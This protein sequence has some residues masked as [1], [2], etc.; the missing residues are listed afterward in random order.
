LKKVVNN[1]KDTLNGAQQIAIALAPL[2]P[3]GPATI[4]RDHV[5]A[6]YYA[7]LGGLTNIIHP[8]LEDTRCTKEIIQLRNMASHGRTVFDIACEGAQHNPLLDNDNTNNTSNTTFSLSVYAS[9]GIARS[10]ARFLHP[11]SLGQYDIPAFYLAVKTNL[12]DI[13]QLWLPSSTESKSDNT[14]LSTSH[15][16]DKD[17]FLY[18]DKDRHTA[19]HTLCLTSISTDIHN[20]DDYEACLRT[21][22]LLGQYITKEFMLHQPDTYIHNFYTD[23]Y[24]A[25]KL[26]SVTLIQ[27]WLT[28]PYWK[29]HNLITFLTNIQL[30]PEQT[31]YFDVVCEAITN[32]HPPII[33]SRTTNYTTILF[34][35][36]K[37]LGPLN[38]NKVNQTIFTLC[39][40]HG[41][42]DIIQY[43][44]EDLQYSQL[45]RNNSSIIQRS[46]STARTASMYHNPYITDEQKSSINNTNA[47]LTTYLTNEQPLLLA[48]MPSKSLSINTNNTSVTSSTVVKEGSINNVSPGTH[49]P[50]RTLSLRN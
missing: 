1:N 33:A 12:D 42:T 14:N 46:L 10:I 4:C 20:D 38:K 28:L 44:L 17:T 39:S 29:Q 15:I 25:C 45:L 22:N 11:S 48:S 26:G 6:L 9:R 40:Q 32:P 18:R 23:F 3:L 16:V 21:G 47:L 13:V 27:E 41:F 50:F 37:I 7:I 24:Y 30:I 43:F 31:T 5:S 19:F 36:A 8:W 49:K 2:L 35:L 34:L